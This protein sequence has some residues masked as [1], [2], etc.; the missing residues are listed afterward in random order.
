MSYNSGRSSSKCV[1]QPR[2]Q[3]AEAKQLVGDLE[4]LASGVW[5][6]TVW[7]RPLH[8]VSNQDVA[9]ERDSLPLHLLTADAR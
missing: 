3:R 6:A 2:F 9:I 5:K 7:Q 1:T 4:P 8:L